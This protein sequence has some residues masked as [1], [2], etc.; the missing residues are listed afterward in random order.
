MATAVRYDC[1]AVF[2]KAF[3]V[4]CAVCTGSKQRFLTSKTATYWFLSATVR[5]NQSIRFRRFACPSVG[6]FILTLYL[7]LSTFAY[8]GAATRTLQL[9]GGF[10]YFF[11]CIA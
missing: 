4:L 5:R 7:D 9:A 3:G 1:A 11:Y 6:L 10:Y 2:T 8:F